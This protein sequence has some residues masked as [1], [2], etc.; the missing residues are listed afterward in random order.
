MIIAWVGVDARAAGDGGVL[1]GLLGRLA[2]RDRHRPV[3]HVVVDAAVRG[4]QDVVAVLQLRDLAERASV[5]GPVRGDDV[6]ADLARPHPT[7]R[8]PRTG[9]DPAIL[10]VRARPV[11]RGPGVRNHPQA[12][13]PRSPGS[14]YSPRAVFVRV[15][16]G[17][18]VRGT[19]GVALGDVD[20]VGPAVGVPA[21]VLGVPGAGRHPTRRLARRAC[22]IST[23]DQPSR[24]HNRTNHPP[25]H[26]PKVTPPTENH[27]K[28]GSVVAIPLGGRR[29]LRAG[30]EYGQVRLGRQPVV[31]AGRDTAGRS[32]APAVS[33]SLGCLCARSAR[34]IPRTVEDVQ[35]PVVVVALMVSSV[36]AF[37]GRPQDGPRA[38][39]SPVGHSEVEV[40]AGL[41]IVGDRYFGQTVHRNAAVTFLDAAAL[42]HLAATLQLPAPP[43]PLL[44]RRNIVL[45][46]FPDRHPRHPPLA[47]RHPGSRPPLHPRLRRR[48]DRVPG[49]PPGQPLRLDGRRTG[50]RCIPSP[51]RPRRHPH[52]PTDLRYPPRRP[53]HPHCA[54]VG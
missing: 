19:D 38:D 47:R 11:V 1:L 39:P 33:G 31:R 54:G 28:T 10:D 4:D 53:C 51:P 37:E 5:R 36:H 17:L 15:A 6:V 34:R 45:R 40:R 50:S 26:L 2:E 7:G 24:H 30:G 43:D 35:I 52:D 46:G 27:P 13:A 48:P 29:H 32:A 20:R 14:S 21:V 8:P 49:S 16:V 41:G 23:P 9:R 18:G 25:P 42:D 22:H 44:L 12:A 3:D